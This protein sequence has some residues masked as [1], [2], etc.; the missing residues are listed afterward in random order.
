MIV[1][2]LTVEGHLPAVTSLKGKR[3]ILQ[4]V[5]KTISNRFNVSI[6]EVGFQDL[7]QRTLIGATSVSSDRNVVENEL[8]RVLE[9]IEARDDLYVTQHTVEFI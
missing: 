5:K 3:Q 7:W 8:R 6:A 4:S 9:T 1:G 2:I